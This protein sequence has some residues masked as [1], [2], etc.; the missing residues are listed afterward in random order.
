MEKEQQLEFWLRGPGTG[1]NTCFT[2]SGACYFAGANGSAAGFRIIFRKSMLWQRPG[3]CGI[4]SLS[5]ATPGW[6]TWIVCLL[7]R[8]G[9][10]NFQQLQLN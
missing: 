6:S 1:H 10:S 7:M 3:R 2:T 5:F 8:E 9:E 4:G